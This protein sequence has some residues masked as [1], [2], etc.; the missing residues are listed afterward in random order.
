MSHPL[1]P[2][3][4]TILLNALS[5]TPQFTT[6]DSRQS[7]IRNELRDYP[8]FGEIDKAL[9][10]V[11]WDRGPFEVAD[12]LIA[13]LDGHEIAPGVPAL[14]LIA[15]AIQPMA[16]SAHKEKLAGLRRRAGWS[17]NLSPELVETW[18]DLRTPAE[19]VHERIIGE[20]TLKHMYFLRRALA[21]A[22]AVV[23]IDRGYPLGTG[24]LVAPTLFMTNHHVIATQREAQDSQVCFFD[25]LP[26]SRTETDSPRKRVFVRTADEPIYTNE[27]LDFTLVRLREPPSISCPLS[28]RPIVMRR[29][30]R[31]TIIQ[32]PGGEPKQISMQNNMVA[33]ADDRLLQYYTSTKPGSSGSPVLDDDF[34]VVAIH[35]SSD[36][37]KAWDARGQVRITDT[38]QIGDLQYRN[39]GT[40]MV[41]VI[42]DLETA[43]PGLLAELNILK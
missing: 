11:N 26:D 31:V 43:A 22:D 8:L 4:R 10:H 6:A 12:R 3:D 29:N 9:R 5:D 16:G 40:A 13:L 7:F 18:R 34:A 15:Q 33:A 25:E 28:L 41:A 23:R 37:N 21:A 30:Q 24:F 32:H 42:A 20:N 1:Q 27:K 39:Q 14:A 38:N 2:Q 19:L 17:A 36:A 35:H